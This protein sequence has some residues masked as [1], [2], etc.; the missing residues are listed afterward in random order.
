MP[1]AGPALN[2]LDGYQLTATDHRDMESTFTQLKGQ[3]LIDRE[4]VVRWAFIELSKG[5]LA[6]FGKLPSHDDLVRAATS[7]ISSPQKV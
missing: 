7:V 1:A 3:F 6:S 2:A 5:G 4:G